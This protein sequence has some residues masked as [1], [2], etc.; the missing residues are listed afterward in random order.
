MRVSIVNMP[1]DMP[2]AYVDW[3]VE[4]RTTLLFKMTW[5]EIKCGNLLTRR[6]VKFIPQC[7]FYV[8][9]RVYFADF[10]APDYNVVLEVDGAYHDEFLQEYSDE[11]RDRALASIGVT[12]CRVRNEDLTKTTVVDIFGD[13]QPGYKRR[14]KSRT[15]VVTRG[16]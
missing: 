11:Q 3:V 16:G 12:T 7:P 5:P 10:Y 9:G 13:T 2:A 14:R 15:I 8:N 4:A 1:H 6:G